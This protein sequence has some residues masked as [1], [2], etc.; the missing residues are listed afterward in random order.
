MTTG[1]LNFPSTSLEVPVNRTIP[2]STPLILRPVDPGYGRNLPYI[3]D[4]SKHILPSEELCPC[5]LCCC[6]LIGTVTVF[7]EGH[8][9]TLSGQLLQSGGKQGKTSKS[10]DCRP[11]VSFL[12]LQCEFLVRSN[13][14]WNTLMVGKAFCKSSSAGFG[15]NIKC[16]KGKP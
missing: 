6:H 7:S 3:N 15:R 14:V 5:P 11:T 1:S 10:H 9:I 8:S 12:W 16:R 2:V 4:C 13:T